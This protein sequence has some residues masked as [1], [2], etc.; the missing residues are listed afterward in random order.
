MKMDSYSLRWIIET[1]MQNDLR[2]LQGLS[3]I[4]TVI[5]DSESDSEIYFVEEEN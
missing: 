4:K 5:V 1:E 3:A 2:K